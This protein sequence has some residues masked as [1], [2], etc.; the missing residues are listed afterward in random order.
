MKGI[1][2]TQ[3]I[4]LIVYCLGILLA[5]IEEGKER[6]KWLIRAHYSLFVVMV[7]EVIF[8]K[9]WLFLIAL[10]FILIQ[11]FRLNKEF[12]TSD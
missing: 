1:E 10:I 9:N 5:L 4:F 8:K 12:N 2:I 3:E 6:L 7:L 11:I